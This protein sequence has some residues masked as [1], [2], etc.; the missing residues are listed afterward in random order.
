METIE[1]NVCYADGAGKQ[2]TP[3]KGKPVLYVF[4]FLYAE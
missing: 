4:V 3:S 1:T 2:A